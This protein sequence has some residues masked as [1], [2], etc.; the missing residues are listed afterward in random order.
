MTRRRGISYVPLLLGIVALVAMLALVD[1]RNVRTWAVVIGFTSVASVGY[2][3]YQEQRA[4]RALSIARRRLGSAPYDELQREMDR[5]RRHERPFALVRIRPRQAAR[6]ALRS[7][8]GPVDDVPRP[9]LVRSTDLV[10]RRGGDLYLL[11]PETASPGAETMLER[12]IGNIAEVAEEYR[13]AAF[14]ADGITV[15]A[16]FAT[17]SAGVPPAEDLVRPDETDLPI[18]APRVPVVQAYKESSNSR[19]L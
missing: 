6:K 10:W 15:G 3:A 12:A 17:L 11:L 1:D 8:F 14:P 7:I 13:V 5:A 4:T 19:R 16:L 9:S 2:G 18:D